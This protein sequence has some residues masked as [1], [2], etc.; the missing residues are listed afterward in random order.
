MEL[1]D[2]CANDLTQ[3]SIRTKKRVCVRVHLRGLVHDDGVHMLAGDLAELGEL[4]APAAAQRAADDVGPAEHI[5]LGLAASI[6]HRVLADAAGIG[7]LERKVKERERVCEKGSGESGARVRERGRR[8]ERERGARMENEGGKKRE[9]ER[10]GG[11][12]RERGLTKR[13]RAREREMTE[14]ER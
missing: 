3:V 14:R 6:A 12:R 13:E 9:L 11:R 7:E 2:F 8:K 5:D 10:E 4:S 1:S